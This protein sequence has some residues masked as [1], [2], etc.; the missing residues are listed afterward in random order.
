[1]HQSHTC[2]L[3]PRQETDIPSILSLASS[4]HHRLSSSYYQSASYLII[5]MLYAGESL[6]RGGAARTSKRSTIHLPSMET[7]TA[8]LHELLLIIERRSHYKYRGMFLPTPSNV[9]HPVFLHQDAALSLFVPHPTSDHRN[10]PRHSS[11]QSLPLRRQ[12]LPQCP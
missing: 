8:P 1:M 10:R 12:G 9:E 3:Q 11:P 2:F 4:R 7:S 6:E 5:P